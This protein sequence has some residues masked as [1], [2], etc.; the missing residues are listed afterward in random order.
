LRWRAASKTCRLQAVNRSLH[1]FHKL[2][3]LQTPF[4]TFAIPNFSHRPA[5]P[6]VALSVAL[7]V[8]ALLAVGFGAAPISPLQVISIFLHVVGIPAPIDFS[9]QQEAILLAI[10]LPRVL[11]AALVGAALAIAGGAMQ[12]AL[13]NP[14]AD[15]SV[16]GVSSGAALAAVAVIIF[17]KNVLNLTPGWLGG[18]ELPVVAFF[19]GLAATLATNHLAGS[20]GRASVSLTILAGIAV[21]ALAEAGRG[22]LLFMA[23]DEQLRSVTFWSLGGLGGATWQNLCALTPFA[24]IPI[25][26]LPRLARSLNVLSLGEAEAGHLG[27][28]IQ[29]VKRMA[30]FL[31]T[32]A[33]AS[34]VAFSGIIFFVGLV[35]PHF[36]RLALGPD[37]RRLLPCS[38][39]LGALLMV[40]ADL[41]ARTLVAPAELPIGVITALIGAPVFFRLIIRERQR[42]GLI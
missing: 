28:D 34:S 29:K 9:D 21:N 8:S 5:A 23:S 18:F 16:V 12:G 1:I 10:R 26:W 11:F 7:G 33:V 31:S 36:V 38:A 2:M 3:P 32:L 39:L 40:L 20:F 4:S 25:L 35:A 13:R 6:T 14:L 42:G 22:A 15:P 19:G 24:L 30:I 17:E 37:H 27:V 41:G